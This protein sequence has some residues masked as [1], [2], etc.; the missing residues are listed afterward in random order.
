MA[1]KC[2]S[3]PDHSKAISASDFLVVELVKAIMAAREQKKELPVEFDADVKLSDWTDKHGIVAADKA[4][5]ISEAR[6]LFEVEVVVRGLAEFVTLSANKVEWKQP[7]VKPGQTTSSEEI[8]RS[9][10]QPLHSYSSANPSRDFCRAMCRGCYRDNCTGC[11]YH[12]E[13]DDEDNC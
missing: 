12:F 13:E 2:S 7:E 4:A 10:S 5:F 1:T 6:A 3:D 8:A 11:D 9:F